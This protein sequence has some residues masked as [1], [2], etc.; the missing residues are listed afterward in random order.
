MRSKPEVT[1]VSEAIVY[2]KRE[3]YDQSEMLSMIDQVLESWRIPY[4]RAIECID[5]SIQDIDEILSEYERRFGVRLADPIYMNFRNRKEILLEVKPLL[6][7][8]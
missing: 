2:A 7:P 8:K 3:A 6:H 5:E 4:S 1:I